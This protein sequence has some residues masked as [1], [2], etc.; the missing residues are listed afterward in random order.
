MLAIMGEE[1]CGC[2]C[3]KKMIRNFRYFDETSIENY[4]AA[5]GIF[6]SFRVISCG[7]L[8]HFLK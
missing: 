3:A 6:S 4:T 8:T 2:Y 1:R 5:N 7:K